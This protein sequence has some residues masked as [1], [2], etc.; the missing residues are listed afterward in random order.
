MLMSDKNDQL[1]T[2]LGPGHHSEGLPIANPNL[3]L[4]LYH[5][6]PSLWR[7]DTLQKYAVVMQRKAKLQSCLHSGAPVVKKMYK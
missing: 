5:S 1:Q 7:A 2:G 6:G 3:T 4:T